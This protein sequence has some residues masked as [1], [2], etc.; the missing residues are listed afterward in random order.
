MPLGHV[1]Q[2]DAMLGISA[3]HEI[4]FE[5]LGLVVGLAALWSP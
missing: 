5:C 4:G 2:I 3:I 1:Y